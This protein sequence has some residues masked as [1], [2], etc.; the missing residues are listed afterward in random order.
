M[1]DESAGQKKLTG[2]GP[3]EN[4]ENNRRRIQARDK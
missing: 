1:A 4:I 2:R 3:N